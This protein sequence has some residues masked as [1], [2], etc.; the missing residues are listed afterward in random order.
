MGIRTFIQNIKALGNKDVRVP[1]VTTI[2]YEKTYGKDSQMNMDEMVANY[3]SWPYACINRNAFSIAKTD[4]YI[5]KETQNKQGEE[6]EQIFQH[7]FLELLKNVNPF[8]N[9][10]ELWTIT[11]I[12]LELTGNAYWWIPKSM[13]GI[14]EVI[15]SIPANWVKIVP[16]EQKFIA[17]Y[18]VKTPQQGT[19]IPFDEEE[20]VHFKYPSPFSLYYGAS[21][22]Q[23]A[24]YG[25]DLNNHTKTWGI[26]FFMNNAQPS[27]VLETPDSLTAEQFTRLRD[28]WNNKYRGSENAGKMAI[29][30][31]G[32]KYNQIGSDMSKMNFTD[33]SRNVRDEILAV[34]GVPASKL[35]LV[36]DVNRANAEANDYTYQKETVLPRLRLIEEKLNEKMMPLYDV[37]LVCKFDNPVPEDKEFRLKESV[38]HIRTGY[39]SIDDERVEDDREPYDL[40]ET[41]VPLLPM[42]LIPAGTPQEEPEE[43]MIEDDPTPDKAITK[44]AKDTHKWQVFVAVTG[45]QEKMLERTMRQF[46]QEQ[47]SEVMKNYNKIKTVKSDTGE[48]SDFIVFDMNEQYNKLKGISAAH[49][50]EAFTSGVG[51]GYADLGIDTFSIIQPNIL[52]SIDG[53]IDFFAKKVNETTLELIRGSLRDGIQAG[54]PISEIGKRLDKIYDFR[55]KNGARTTAQTEVIGAANSG[56]LQAYIEAGVKFKR[57]LTAKDEKVRDSHRATDKQTVGITE[58]FTTGAG[59]KL[60]YPGDR[61]SSAP[62][63]EVINCRCTVSPIVK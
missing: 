36:E 47:Y 37:G 39:S 34:F 56:Q 12:Y 42:S 62:A 54:E 31:K 18:V 17:G 1:W 4:L 49:I 46:F 3:K 53:R 9:K 21:P 8:F 16:S 59:A 57:W 40:P 22:L 15:W 35:G 55:I 19:P 48:L 24:A 28:M 38:E 25:V 45:P 26:N 58:D 52:R 14:P 13:L 32:L 23:A 20:I 10:F 51:L 63:G 44:A 29:L 30:E 60:Q 27:G 5:Y 6:L 11:S 2:G 50:S 41:T 7:P 61:S 33:L 43:P